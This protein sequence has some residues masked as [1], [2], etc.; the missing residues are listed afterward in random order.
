MDFYDEIDAFVFGT[1]EGSLYTMAVST[2]EVEEVGTLDSAVLVLEVSPDG[3]TVA[4]ITGS[5]K[6][7]LM[8]QQWEVE[9]ET[10]LQ[11]AIENQ[12]PVIL[13]ETVQLMPGSVALSWRGDCKAFCS[14]SRSFDECAPPEHNPLPG[15]S[16]GCSLCPCSLTCSA[17]SGLQTFSDDKDLE[18]S[19]LHS[20]ALWGY[21][22]RRSPGVA[23]SGGLAAK[24]A[25]HLLRS[26]NGPTPAHVLV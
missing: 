22:R 18:S 17:Q 5:G 6:L 19:R 11:M 10:P 26:G 13:E 21:G 24:W 9:G 3:Q 23:A 4:L 12:V 8:N 15:I 16:E 25:P 14:V 1:I 7:L 20:A 2:G